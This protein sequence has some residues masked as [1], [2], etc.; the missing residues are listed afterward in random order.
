MAPFISSQTVWDDY[1][2]SVKS[3]EHLH[4]CHSKAG[5]AHHQRVDVSRS[6]SVA[7]PATGDQCVANC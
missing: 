4:V 3:F 2:Y 1:H 5:L 7:C 6:A